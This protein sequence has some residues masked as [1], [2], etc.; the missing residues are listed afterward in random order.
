M[1]KWEYTRTLIDVETF[2]MSGSDQPADYTL[3]VLGDEG[4]ELAVTTP[5][6]NPKVWAFILK[7]PRE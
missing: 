1:Q 4:W 2:K 3:D 5:T 7:R 6:K